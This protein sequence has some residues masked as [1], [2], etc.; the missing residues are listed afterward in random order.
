[1]VK[2]ATP[3]LVWENHPGAAR[4]ARPTRSTSNANGYCRRPR[5]SG[6]PERA[7]VHGPRRRRRATT[8]ARRSRATAAPTTFTS[9]RSPGGAATAAKPCSW[10]RRAPAGRTRTVSRTASRPSI[11]RIASAPASRAAPIDLRTPSPATTGGGAHR[12]RSRDRPEQRT[13]QQRQ[14]ADP[15]RGRSP[16]MQ[17]YLWRGPSF[18]AISG[19]DDA[20]ILY[21][22]YTHGLSNRLVTDAAGRGALNSAQA[23]AMGEGWSDWYARTSSSRSS[24]RSTRGATGEVDMGDYMDVGAHALRTQALD[25]PVSRGRPRCPG[26]ARPAPVATPTATSAGSTARPGDPRRRRDLGRDAVGPAQRRGLGG[27]AP[28]DHRRHAAVAARALVPGRAQRDPARRPGRGRGAARGDLGGLRGRAGWATTRRP[29]ARPT[30]MPLEDFS[31]PP[32]AGDPRGRIAGTITDAATGAAVPKATVAI[33]GLDGGPGQTGR[34]DRRGGQLRDRGRPGP[35]L[36]RALVIGAPGYDS[37]DRTGR[38]AADTTAALNAALNRN[39]AAIPGGASVTPGAG[40]AD[41]AD[42]GCGPDAAV[43]QREGSGWSTAASPAG[44]SIVIT[45]PAPVDVTEFATDPAEVCGDDATSAAGDFLIE[46]SPTSAD[47]PWTTAAAG[48]FGE[49]DR[50]RLNVHPRKRGRRAPRPAD[51]A[52][53]PRAAA[54]LRHDRVRRPRDA[55][56]TASHRPDTGG[57]RRRRRRS[58]RRTPTPVPTP[59]A[60]RPSRSRSAGARR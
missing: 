42:Q 60:R 52:R 49:A 37:T 36:T 2:S 4:A 11:W 16:I 40:S 26:R 27:R 50:H 9:R 45:L 33:D 19:G 34:D 10:T 7:R 38:R 56:P 12:R 58:R 15:A 48:R 23:G 39:W 20:A 18:R 44:K 8:S 17:M 54:V 21:H 5:H 47:G 46:T 53:T 31:A 30:S 41:Y 24:R 43:D 57:R 28:P 35:Q 22:E 32:T 13:P 51:A 1:M 14:H 25:C 55:P 6:C 59:L 29:T 3:A